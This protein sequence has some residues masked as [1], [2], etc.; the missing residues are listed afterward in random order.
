MANRIKG[1][2]IEI[3]GDTS[4]LSESL[5]GVNKDLK[6][7]Q[8][9]LKDV[10]KLLKLDPSNVELLRQKQGY[11]NDAIE[12]SKEK[13]AKEKEA[14]EQLKNSEGF[15][16]NSEQAKALE[17]Q[18]AEDEQ[19]LK[20]L[21][22]E[23]K[24][25]GSVGAQQFKNVGNEV[26]AVGDK[27][28]NIG[29]GMSTRVTA[30][31]MGI[32]AAGI[33]AFKEVDAG[34]DTI[35]AKTGASG[36]ALEDM[37]G[38]MENIAS[39]VP[40]DFET[41]G[42]TVGEVNTRFHITGQELEDLSTDFIKFA[43]INGTDVNNA[44]DQTQKA[45]SAFGLGAE[46]A[47][48]LL[49]VMN[50]TGQ[51][52]GASMDSLMNGL[53]QNGTA[54][55]EMG[56]SIEQATVFMGQME[57]SGAN[58]ETVMNGLRKA[59]KNATEE[60]VPLNEALSNL[61]DTIL[62]GTDSMDGLTAAYDMFGKSGDQI[63]AAVK[64]GTLDFNALAL[65]A[66]DAGGSV[67]E[68][69]EG[70][71]DPVDKFQTIMNKAKIAGADLG[72]AIQTAALPMIEK[73]SSIIGELTEKFRSLTPE[74][75]QTIVKIAGIIAAVGPALLIIGKLVSAVGSIISV[76]GTLVGVLGGP[77]TLAIAAVIAAGVM[78]YKHWDEVKEYASKL[79]D[80]LTQKWTEIKTNVTNKITELKTQTTEK[81]EQIKNNVTSK[82]ESI[83]SEV[84]NKFEAIRSAIS[85]KINAAK[86]AVHNAIEAMK[87][88]FNFH[89]E[90]PHISLPH[91]SVSGSANPLDWLTEG[92][93]HISVDWYRKAYDNPIMF[94]SP[95][96]LQT[97]AGLKGFGDGSGA[98]I[99]MGLNKLRELVGTSSGDNIEINVYGAQGQDVT[100][101]AYE[102]ERVLVRAQKSRSAVFA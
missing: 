32:G 29:K 8:D 44:I 35:V 92:V 28:S 61:Q 77:L 91:F 76:I 89:W 30:P 39:T 65:S 21:E 53:V 85:D 13:L 62:N 19:A 16:K 45:L 80:W 5:K 68:T 14:L 82:V 78:L 94:T 54:F 31:I 12:A 97:A 96:V 43:T 37:K 98:E 51:D 101:L 64:N 102:V 84:T 63:Y 95:T 41:I 55:Q 67:A 40:T 33:A 17:R 27:I 1:I 69:F 81:F 18:I 11:L 56:L 73:L 57:T 58:S 42:T 34:L 99:V 100:A 71:I 60:G 23:A 93:P 15:D 87:G 9:G 38:I 70:T 7:A 90:L 20:S 66:E 52:T 6:T 36:D 88:F 72:E 83:K 25:F 10:E 2:T 75:Q 3:G 24:K 46:D 47:S 79:K 49:D 22:D 59:L 4:K 48:R 50:K 74:Q 26:K 86:D